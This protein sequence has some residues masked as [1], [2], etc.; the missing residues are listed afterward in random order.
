[1]WQYQNT[2]NMYIGRFQ[3]NNELYHYGI[4][5]MKWRNKKISK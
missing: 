4:L 3:D 1:M 2:D 5:G